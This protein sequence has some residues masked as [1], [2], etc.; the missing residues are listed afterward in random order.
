MDFRDLPLAVPFE[1]SFDAVLGLAYDAVEP[2]EVRAHL[3][4]RSELLDRNGV[5]PLSVFT[6]VAEGTASVGTAYQVIPEGFSA[7]G[8][9]NNTTIVAGVREGRVDVLARR[10]A[11]THDLWTWAVE[12]RDSDGTLVATSTVLIAVR[13]R[14]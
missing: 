8:L 10:E 13:A 1:E 3:D 6:A 2:T 7:S 9:A 4:A 12:A 14:Q 11:A 5:V